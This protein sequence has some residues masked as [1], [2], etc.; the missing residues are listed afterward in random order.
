MKVKLLTFA[1]LLATFSG[2]GELFDEDST[3]PDGSVPYITVQSPYD[4][5]VY[6]GQEVVRIK[7]EISDKDKIQ[8]LEVHVSRTDGNNGEVWG[9]KKFPKKNPVLIDTTFSAAG[10][11]SGNYAIT[12]NTIDGRTN[13]GTKVIRFSIK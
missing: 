4:N 9:Y 10:L 11:A 3:A 12:L 7:S 2:C 13:V 8:Q 5:T 1:L 6:S